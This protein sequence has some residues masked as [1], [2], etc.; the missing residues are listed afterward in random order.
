MRR[1]FE[2][3]RQSYVIEL[4]YAVWQEETSRR[5]ELPS[6]RNAFFVH[7]VMAMAAGSG[8][9]CDLTTKPN[10]TGTCNDVKTTPRLLRRCLNTNIKSSQSNIKSRL[11]R[12]IPQTKPNNISASI[13]RSQPRQLLNRDLRNT[14]GT[15]EESSSNGLRCYGV[16]PATRTLYSSV[17][18][19]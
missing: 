18:N 19:L 9:R 16:H 17:I 1:S 6:E 15:P 4:S 10:Y 13:Q 14:K 5:Y 3:L 2:V 12:S 7:G 11:Y 8:Y